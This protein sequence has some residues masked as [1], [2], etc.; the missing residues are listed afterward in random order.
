MEEAMV[1]QQLMDRGRHPYRTLLIWG[2]VGLVMTLIGIGLGVRELAA[3]ES[4]SRAQPE[5]ATARLVQLLQWLLGLGG[6]AGLGTA[7]LLATLAH[8]TWHGER[9]PPRQIKM[10][11]GSQVVRG[12]AARK[13]ALVALGLATLLL[14]WAL[15]AAYHAYSIPGVL[16]AN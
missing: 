15:F 8:Y 2:G 6:L 11:R 13:R 3:I 9:F 7:G 4:I 5:L 1:K 14:G 12:K 10:L 16:I